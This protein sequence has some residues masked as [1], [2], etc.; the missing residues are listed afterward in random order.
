MQDLR[1]SP[2]L[3]IGESDWIQIVNKDS[4][5]LEYPGEISSSLI[6]NH[7]GVSKFKNSQDTN[8]NNVRN[9]LKRMKRK[10]VS[11]ATRDLGTFI[12]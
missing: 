4:A 10:F 5:L 2:P 9:V 1:T 8:Y 6:A 11:E 12:S 7:H 3:N